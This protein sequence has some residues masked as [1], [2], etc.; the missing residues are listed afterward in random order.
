MLVYFKPHFRLLFQRFLQT[1][2]LR[3]FKSSSSLSS[4]YQLV[5]Q[6][7]INKSISSSIAAAAAADSTRK[8]I[9]ESTRPAVAFHCTLSVVLASV[10]VVV[11][12]SLLV[13][14]RETLESKQSTP[15]AEAKD[16]NSK[17]LSSCP[18]KSPSLE[19]LVESL[20]RAIL[21]CSEWLYDKLVLRTTRS[22]RLEN[23]SLVLV[24]LC[25]P[26]RRRRSSA[27][28]LNCNDSLT[29]TT[30]TTTTDWPTLRSS[31]ESKRAKLICIYLA[32]RKYFLLS[33][34]L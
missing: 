22:R 1:S 2:S 7:E 14:S 4:V 3:S 32:E 16:C 19:Q 9:S 34:L 18:I 24:P 27:E 15:A 13:A 8:L 26:L 10:L 21:T 17:A 28:D 25:S 11:Q 29:S 20:L 33:C 5:N 30:T 6:L 23:S 12:S 31:I